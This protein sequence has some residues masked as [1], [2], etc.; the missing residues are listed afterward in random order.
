MPTPNFTDTNGNGLTT[1]LGDTAEVQI[2]CT[3]GVITPG[4]SNIVGGTVQVAAASSF[5][6][7]AGMTATGLGA[8]AG[9]R[10]ERRIQR[11][12]RDH[13]EPRARAD[14]PFVVEFRD[15]SGGNPTMAW[16]FPDD[17]STSSVQDP[18]VHT[19][20]DRGHL[21]GDDDGHE[22]D[23]FQRRV[24]VRHC[25][26]GLSG[27]LHRSPADHRASGNRDLHRYLDDRRDGLG[28]DVRRRGGDRRATGEGTVTHTYNTPGTYT[29]SLT[30]TY[31]TGPLTQTKTATSRSTSGCARSPTL[32][33]VRFNDA[34]GIWQG[35]PYNFTGVVI[36][37]PAPRPATS[38][39]PPSRDLRPSRAPCNSDV[40]V[41]RP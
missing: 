31:P 18:L 36:G 22:H 28:L 24:D 14:L 12:R 32:N 33:G 39:S 17:G 3:F 11:E 40:K 38:S 27:R 35:P 6:V 30:V 26:S 37:H 8:G 15:T 9:Q 1:D 21:R 13:A 7:K 16:T 25:D 19:F 5:P 34:E 20:L 10:P 4:I 41:N 29:V 2:A 23:G